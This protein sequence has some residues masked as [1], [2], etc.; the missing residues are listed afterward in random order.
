[1]KIKSAFTLALLLSLSG[2]LFAQKKVAIEYGPMQKFK[3]SE[4]FLNMDIFSADRGNYYALQVPYNALYNNAIGGIRNYHLVKYNSADL[5]KT[6]A[7][8]MDV[9][10]ED[11]KSYL[12]TALPKKNHSLFHVVV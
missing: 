5:T 10:E 9:V 1:M 4:S 8:S 6:A 3:F 2:G 12:K 7:F 11:K